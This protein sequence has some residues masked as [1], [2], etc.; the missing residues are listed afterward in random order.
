MVHDD[1]FLLFRLA[2]SAIDVAL[3]IQFIEASAKVKPPLIT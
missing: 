2:G 3:F 1:F